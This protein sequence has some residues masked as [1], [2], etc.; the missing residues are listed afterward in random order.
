MNIAEVAVS[1]LKVVVV[2]LLLGAGLPALF[3]IGLRAVSRTV[4]I[5]DPQA[6]GEVLTRVSRLGLLLGYLCFTVV[7]LAVLAGIG[8]IIV[9]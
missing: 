9:N 2:G 7:G 4:D 6:P 1:L 8:W 5:A 3:A